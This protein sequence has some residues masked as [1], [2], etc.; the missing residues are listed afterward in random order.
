V[1]HDHE[2]KLFEVNNLHTRSL[3]PAVCMTIGRTNQSL[4]RWSVNYPGA[5]LNVRGPEY[6]CPPAR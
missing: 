6:F 5:F 2:A 3:L 4:A 1:I